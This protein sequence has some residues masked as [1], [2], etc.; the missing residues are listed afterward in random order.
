[1]SEETEEQTPEVS[2]DEPVQD[3]GLV[4]VL[5]ED[6]NTDPGVRRRRIRRR[7]EVPFTNEERI[8]IDDEIVEANGN[9]IKTEV[10]KSAQNKLYNGHIAEYRQT[11]DD[12]IEVLRKGVFQFEMERIEEFNYTEKL[13]IY[14]DVE[15]DKEIDRRDM[16][17][18]ELQT[19]MKM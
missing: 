12:A 3:T 19:K 18:E 16:T 1:M 10:E 13:V 11:L 7:E 4:V 5:S 6:P 14:Y 9:L 17:P 2:T 15:T 8:Q